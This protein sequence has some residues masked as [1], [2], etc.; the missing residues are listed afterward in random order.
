M[1][2]VKET[3]NPLGTMLPEAVEEMAL[4]GRGLNDL[5]YNHSFAQSLFGV[6]Q[7]KSWHQY[8]ERLEPEYIYQLKKMAVYP[9]P[10]E[11]LAKYLKERK[12]TE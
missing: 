2:L 11:F 10:L 5:L 8:G 6:A 7:R 1:G 9:E 12:D 3:G 4:T